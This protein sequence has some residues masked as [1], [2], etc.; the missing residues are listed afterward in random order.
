MLNAFEETVCEYLGIW[1]TGKD[2]TTSSIQ[3][4]FKRSRL[5][6]K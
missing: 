6:A 1:V 3:I 4:Q 5:L 2:W